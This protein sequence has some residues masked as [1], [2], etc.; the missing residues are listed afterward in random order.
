MSSEQQEVAYAFVFVFVFVGVEDVE[1]VFMA[2]S[3]W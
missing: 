1:F 2:N 3:G